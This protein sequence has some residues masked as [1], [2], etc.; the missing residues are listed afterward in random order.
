MVFGKSFCI[1]LAQSLRIEGDHVLRV[2]RIWRLAAYGHSTSTEEQFPAIL[3]LK[4]HLGL[5]GTTSSGKSDMAALSAF[6]KTAP[7]FLPHLWNGQDAGPPAGRLTAGSGEGN[8][9][10]CSEAGRAIATYK[11]DLQNLAHQILAAISNKCCPSLSQ[12]C[13]LFVLKDSGVER[14][15]KT[16]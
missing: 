2:E 6:W 4:A 12:I 7:V 1:L 16:C 11:S 3:L 8:A 9:G 15:K 5:A 10:P 14:P 13:H